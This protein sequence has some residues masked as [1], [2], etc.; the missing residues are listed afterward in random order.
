[1]RFTGRQRKSDL[2]AARDYQEALGVFEPQVAAAFGRAVAQRRASFPF[3]LVTEAIASQAISEAVRLAYGDGIGPLLQGVGLTPGEPSMVDVLGDTLRAGGGAGTRQLGPVRAKLVASL[4][5]TNPEAVTY[6]RNHLPG[7]IK[8]IDD[9]SREAIRV[10]VLRGME[11]GRP[12]RKVAREVRESIGLTPNQARFVGN[13]RR[14]L[15]TGELGS[16]SETPPHRRRLSATEQQQ[17]RSIFMAGGESSGRVNKLVE[18]YAQRLINRRAMDIARTETHR[19]F[20]QGQKAI[21]GQA[22]DQ[23]LLDLEDTRRIWV[24][25]ADERLR[26]DHAAVPLMNPEG[27]RLNEPFKTPVGPVMG[28]GESGEPG[29]D[30]NERC[31]IA[32]MFTDSPLVYDP[33]AKRY[34]RESL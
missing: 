25:T 14:Q 21:W 16:P 29:F 31:T 7:Q 5:L 30:I 18:T 20:Q 2:L 12:F 28:P 11:E 15:E 34:R 32:L 1:L 6:L 27:V 10:S 8:H 23:G 33:E 24:V 17:S 4:D 19:A 9:V 22:V 13:Y 26:D 3:Q